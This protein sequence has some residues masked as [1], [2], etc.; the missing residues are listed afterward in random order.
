M[1]EEVRVGRLAC[2]A[3]WLL[4]DAVCVA[5]TGL[6]EFQLKQEMNYIEMI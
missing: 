2:P 3:G 5:R 4:E 6:E 1:V